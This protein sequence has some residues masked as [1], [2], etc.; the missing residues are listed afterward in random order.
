MSEMCRPLRR[1]FLCALALLAQ[2]GL[3]QTVPT[4]T[5]QDTVYRADGTPAQGTLL[6]SWPEFTTSGG[7]AI[8]AGTTSVTLGTGGALS[9]ALVSNANATPPSTVYSVVYQLNDGTVKTEYWVVPT[10]SPATLAAVRTTLGATSSVAQMATQQYVNAALATKANDAAVVHLAGTETITGVKQFTVSPSFPT[11][12]QPTDAANKA[13]VDNAVQVTG[14]GSYLS[15]SGGT[16]TG[17]LTLSGDPVAPSQAATKHYTDISAAVKA[18]LIGGLVPPT[19][20]ASGTASG[21]TCLLGNQTWGSCGAGGSSS[22]IN[23][24]LIANPNFNSATPAPQSN[25]LNCSFQNTSSDVSLQCPYGNT[26][27]TFALGSQAVLNSQAN[28]YGAGLQDFSAASLKLPS[29]AGYAPATSG[30]IGFDTTANAPVINVSGVTQQLALT[31]SNISGQ[32]STALALAATPAQCNGSFATGIQANGNANCTTADVIQLAETSQPAGLPNYGIFWFD[33]TTHTPRIIDNN[34]QVEQLALLNVFNADAN[35]LEEYNGTNPQTLNVYGTR[36]DASDYERI[37]LS[38]DTSDGY[39]FIGADAAGTGTQ[40]GLGFWL[41]GGLRWVV[42]SAFNFKPWS[43]NLKDIGTATLRVHNLY[44]GTGLVFNS[45]TLSGVHGTTGVAA[46]A[47]TLGTTAGAGLCNDGNGNVTDQGCTLGAVSSVFGRSGVVVPQTGDYSVAQIT[48]AAP[49]ASPAFSGTPTAPTQAALDNSTKLATTAYTDSAVAVEKTRAQGAEALLAPLASPAL[50]GTPTAPTPATSDNSTKLATTAW[51]NA[52]GFGSGSGNVTGPGSSTTGDIASFSGT[53]GKTIQDS[54]MAVSSLAPLVSPAFTGT[55]TAPTQAALDNSTKLATTAY[56]DSAVAVEKTRAQGA[57]AL[58]APLAGPALTGTPTAP[59]PA[60]SDSSTKLATT[61]Y[62]QNQGFAPLTSPTLTGTPT[63]PTPATSDSSTKLATTAWVNAQGYGTSGGNVSGPSSSTSGDLATFNGTNGKAIQD[64]GQ[65]ISAIS[66]TV[67]KASSYLAANGNNPCAAVVAA[68]GSATGPPADIT[69]VDARDLTG[70]QACGSTNLT[71]NHCHILMNCSKWTTDVGFNLGVAQTIDGPTGGDN[72]CLQFADTSS[73]PGTGAVTVATATSGSTSLTVNK[74]SGETQNLQ[75]NDEIIFSGDSTVTPYGTGEY[76]VTAGVTLTSGGGP[77]TISVTPALGQ[78]ES[79]TIT[80]LHPVVEFAGTTATGFSG[81]TAGVGLNN[82]SITCSTAHGQIGFRNQFSQENTSLVNLSESNCGPRDGEIGNQAPDSMYGPIYSTHASISSG[83]C[84]PNGVGWRIWGQGGNIAARITDVANACNVSGEA[85]LI[86]VDLEGAVGAVTGVGNHD[87]ASPHVEGFRYAT[88]VGYLSQANGVDISGDNSCPQGVGSTTTTASVSGGST[89]MSVNTVFAQ[90]HTGVGIQAPYS[91]SGTYFG[92]ITN[93]SG[94]TLT[95]S[96]ATAGGST[97]ASG[98]TVK[99]AFPDGYG[100]QYSKRIF[101]ASTG[102]AG[103]SNSTAGVMLWNSY[104]NTGS[105]LGWLQDDRGGNTLTPANNQFVPFYLT[106]LAGGI[107]TDANPA[108]AG[109][110]LFVYGNS[111][112][113]YNAGTNEFQLNAATGVITA[114]TPATSDNSTKVA[115]TAWVNATL[116]GGSPVS[117]QSNS[118]TASSATANA[119]YVITCSSACTA[120]LPSSL[121]S[122]LP[123]A[124]VIQNSNSTAT[125]SVNPNGQT[126]YINGTAYTSSSQFTL[127]VG[128]QL[129]I[130]ASASAYYSSVPIVSVPG[131]GFPTLNQNTT[132]TAANLS[133]TPALPNGTTA[134]T[135]SAKDGT[136]KLAT[137]AY[138]D[139]EVPAATVQYVVFPG[140]NSGNQSLFPSG[141]YA[142]LY[143]FELPFAV[144]TSKVAYKTG[145]TADNTSNIYEVGIYSSSGTLL[146]SYQAAGSSFAAATSTWYRQSWSQGSTTLQP[147]RYYEAITTSCSSPCATFWGS[148]STTAAYYSNSAFSITTGGTLPPSITAPS[149]GYES[150]GANT[151]SIILE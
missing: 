72:N 123:W 37:R 133:G 3:T 150:F 124:A 105:D 75:P 50:T 86:G 14:S 101:N 16:M 119:F 65:T 6:I 47:G 28:T 109:T 26:S 44:L 110:G 62:V 25:F 35:T 22:Y 143:S 132:G 92:T 1:L 41:E 15:T 85:P 54:G 114:A 99:T 63:A 149:T 151:L 111:L 148:G 78:T 46:E 76:L 120:A 127:P 87:V 115:T 113:G 142:A 24:T 39:F 125:V 10:T 4:T 144:T 32:A 17:P 29:G 138:A 81:A 106:D 57:E 21:S 116:F 5:V 98:A 45:G 97:I 36:T 30:A 52:Q 104:A 117:L 51:V 122:Q 61:A 145:T 64:S 31:T 67:P 48:G 126:L 83:M 94:T 102:A 100:C 135:Q 69:W 88:A 89:T 141:N 58:L 103:A 131:S 108:D 80:I 18:D 59:T 74:A 77:F 27:S 53:N 91:G 60:T 11:P 13:Y 93:I 84:A 147:G 137:D 66:I 19:E 96:P 112:Y 121:P 130:T 55:P 129:Y 40:R 7:Q 9:V 34:G 23:N 82:A 140:Y 43:D 71:A 107:F 79:G 90:L 2:A 139:A 12:S 38:Y 146:L 33:S 73:F 95:I 70:T 118:F 56:T 128:Q 134:T 8:A 136:T 68:C 42:D 49:L 20:L